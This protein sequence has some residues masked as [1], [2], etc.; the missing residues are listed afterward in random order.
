MGEGG[1]QMGKSSQSEDS[2]SVPVSGGKMSLGLKMGL[3]INTVN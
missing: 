1:V 3:K 2:L